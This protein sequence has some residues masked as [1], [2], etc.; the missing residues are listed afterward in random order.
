MTVLNIF[1][2]TCRLSPAPTIFQMLENTANMIYIIYAG[3]KVLIQHVPCQCRII[4]YSPGKPWSFDRLTQTYALF[5][6]Q[7]FSDSLYIIF[8]LWFCHFGVQSSLIAPDNFHAT[9]VSISCGNRTFQIYQILY[10]SK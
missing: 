1:N 2:V 4:V 6:R 7:S 8:N 9:A 3:I 5:I 10:I